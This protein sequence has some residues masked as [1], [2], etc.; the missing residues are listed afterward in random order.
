VRGHV[1]AAGVV[2][3]LGGGGRGPQSKVALAAAAGGASEV[4]DADAKRAVSGV[5]YRRT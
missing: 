1:V 4:V 2:S 3:E 5:N